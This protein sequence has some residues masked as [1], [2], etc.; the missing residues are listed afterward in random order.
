MS[1][2]FAEATDMKDSEY[3]FAF[4]SQIFHNAFWPNEPSPASFS[5]FSFFRTIITFLREINVKNVHAV[6]GARI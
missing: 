2:Q 4:K 3:I 1:L 6:S 5:L